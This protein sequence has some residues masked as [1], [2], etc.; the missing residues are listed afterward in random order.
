MGMP[1]AVSQR[2]FLTPQ[3][4]GTINAQPESTTSRLFNTIWHTI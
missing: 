3:T 4:F 2:P 1:A